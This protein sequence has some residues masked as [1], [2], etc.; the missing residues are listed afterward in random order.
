MLVIALAAWPLRH[1][2]QQRILESTALT[3][4]APSSEVVSQTIQGAAD[5]VH[6]ILT[7]W[8]SGHVVPRTVAL[9][10]LNSMLPKMRPIPESVRALLTEASMDADNGIRELSLGMMQ[11]ISHPQYAGALAT[12]LENVD[13]EI[14]LMALRRLRELPLESGMPLAIQHLNDSDPRIIG[15]ALNLLGRW[16]HQDFGV[17]LADTVSVGEDARGI[18]EFRP[19]THEMAAAGAERARQWLASH[20]NQFQ[21]Q[22]TEALAITGGRISG[23]HVEDFKL[24]TIDGKSVRLSDFRGK[25][26]LVNF[27]TTWCSACVGEI[28]TLTELQRRHAENLVVLGISL[29]GV[30]DEHGHIGGH[31][32]HTSGE[33]HDHEQ[34]PSLKELRQ[35]VAK[36][37]E[38]RGMKY[39]VLLDPENS[40]GGRFNGGEL[41]TT[42]LID[43]EGILR[44]R[45]VGGRHLD[46]FE[47]MIG[48]MLSSPHLSASVMP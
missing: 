7:A 21:F 11:Q 30:P 41:P 38:R 23:V 9:Q 48:E 19:A 3:D 16:T 33:D 31:E 1:F 22:T 47:A 40:V 36:F 44:R 39:R 4:L 20:T 43:G 34:S 6:A 27:W 35:Q 17:R 2:L 10:E 12:Q 28:P 14:R 29:D 18:P 32:A 5:P 37:A 26:V 45:F 25:R 15:T 13:P 42:L 24:Q 46:V 8:S